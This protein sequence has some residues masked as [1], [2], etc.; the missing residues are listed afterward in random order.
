MIE[1]DGLDIHF[2]MV[3]IEVQRDILRLIEIFFIGNHTTKHF[4]LFPLCMLYWRFCLKDR[5]ILT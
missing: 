4:E 1:R 5:G 3:C 2:T